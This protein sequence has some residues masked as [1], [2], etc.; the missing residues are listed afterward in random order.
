MSELSR[1]L[2]LW[3]ANNP[4]SEVAPLAL[5]ASEALESPLSDDDLIRLLLDRPQCCIRLCGAD[6]KKVQR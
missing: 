6:F 4:R 1:K 5:A 3:A 2:A